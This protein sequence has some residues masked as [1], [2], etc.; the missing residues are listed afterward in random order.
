MGLKGDPVYLEEVIRGAGVSVSV[1]PGALDRGHGDCGYVTHVIDHHTG[2]PVGSNP[3]PGVIANHP[4]LGLC[5]QIH[6]SRKGHATVCGVGIAW[7]A[8]N[9][10]WPGLPTNNANSMTIGIEAENSGT[11]GWSSEQYWAYVRINAAILRKIKEDSSH[12]IGHKEWAG[13]AQGKWDPG[14]MDMNKFR[15]DIG[16]MMAEL[17]GVKPAVPVIEN[18][19]D[20]VRFFSDWLGK[21]LHEGE[22]K[23]KD[24]VGRYVD[25]E[26]GSIYWHPDTGAVP[27][28]K[29]V[30][31]VW[32]ARGWEI[33]FLGYPQRFHVV[34][35]SEGD[36]QSFQGGTIARRYGTAGFVCH[37]VIGRRWVEE[38][39]VRGVDG[40]PTK[41]G[42]PTSDEY[43][44][45]GGRRQDF[46]RGSLVW[47]PSGAIQILGEK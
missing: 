19:I 33:E 17:D 24:G 38:G 42:W 26:N 14:G 6:L 10:S 30:Y 28:P 21:R 35:E 22:R 34:Y 12:S 32:A 11:E 16:N 40:N 47:H 25:F 44:F 31:E 39:G 20:R 13:P 1:F 15:A 8:G 27:V 5:S 2:A 37:G 3:G 4:S 36:L 29:L 18:Q 7:H 46:E 23:C 45:D 9:G 41:L 43:D